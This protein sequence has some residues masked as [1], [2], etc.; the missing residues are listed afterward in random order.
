MSWAG[1]QGAVEREIGHRGWENGSMSV[2]VLPSLFRGQGGLPQR[3]FAGS[4]STDNRV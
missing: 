1:G 3:Q 2:L 4:F